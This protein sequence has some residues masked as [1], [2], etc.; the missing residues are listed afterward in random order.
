MQNFRFDCP[1]A[2]QNEKAR[3]REIFL[4]NAYFNPNLRHHHPQEFSYASVSFQL[5]YHPPPPH[6]ATPLNQFSSTPQLSPHISLN[7]NEVRNSDTH[8]RLDWYQARACYSHP[9]QLTR[10]SEIEIH[11]VRKQESSASTDR[12]ILLYI[13]LPVSSTL[14][15]WDISW[16]N[17]SIQRPTT[18]SA[19]D[20]WS[21]STFCAG[22]LLIFKKMDKDPSGC[23]CFCDFLHKI[24]FSNGF[25]SAK[26]ALLFKLSDF[27]NALPP[28][29]VKRGRR[30]V[31]E[32]VW[33]EKFFIFVVF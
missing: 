24:G 2:S 11:S 8:A 6:P 4:F 12:D 23:T 7:L 1:E 17:H 19:A 33:L 28:V 30:S 31:E 21:A 18:Y 15:S 5:R 20:S 13:D 27:R 16:R 9:T 22:K 14:W 3:V 32:P 26:A 29:L 25:N 10:Q